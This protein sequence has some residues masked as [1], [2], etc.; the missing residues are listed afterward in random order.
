MMEIGLEMIEMVTEFKD[1]RMVPGM[2]ENGKIIRLME[3]ENF[4]ML[5]EMYLKER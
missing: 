5:M 3:K 2:R 1:G 4:I